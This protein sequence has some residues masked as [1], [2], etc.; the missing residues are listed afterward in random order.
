[1]FRHSFWFGLGLASVWIIFYAIYGVTIISI[2]EVVFSEHLSLERPYL[3]WLFLHINDFFMFT[4]WPLSLLAVVGVWRV[5]QKLGTRAQPTDGDILTLTVFATLIIFDLSGTLRGETGRILLLLSPFILLVAAHMLRGESRQLETI[6]GWSL[7]IVQAVMVL[8][9]LAF[10]RVVDSGL[11]EVPATAPIQMTDPQ[12]PAIINSAVFGDVFRLNAFT[13]HV[14][15]HRDSNG[16]RQSTLVLW[17]DWESSGQVDVPYFVSLLPVA[18]DGRVA[19]AA[20]LVQPFD[21]AYPTTCWLPE[22][23]AI[24]DQLE[25]PLFEVAGGDWW[26]SLSLIDGQTGETLDVITPDGARDHQ[27]GIGPFYPILDR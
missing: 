20:T 15:T 10:L 11:S 6:F 8:V 3:P 26:L 12:S 4:G 25:V 14:E 2:F 23:G 7:T 13:G 16:V 19:A 21:G 18:P 27:V 24:R 22:S 1:M 9:L 17:L 5:G